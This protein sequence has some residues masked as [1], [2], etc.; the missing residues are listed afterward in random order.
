MFDDCDHLSGFYPVEQDVLGPFVWTTASGQIRLKRDTKFAQWHLCYYGNEGRLT[1]RNQRAEVI[2][3]VDLCRG[4]H[5][6]VA[7]W[8]ATAGDTIHFQVA[9]LIPVAGEPRELG[10]MLRRIELFDDQARFDRFVTKERNLGLNQREYLTGRSVLESLPPQIRINMEVRCNIPE[11]GQAC[12]YCAWDWAKEAERGSPS[13]TLNTLDELGDL[14]RSAVEVVDCSFGD[15]TMNKDFGPII[16]RLD[17]DGKQVSLTT[18]GQ[19]LTP[20]RRRELLGK[21]VF[22]YVSIDSATAAGYARYRNHRFDDII[23]NLKALC[24]EKKEHNNLPRLHVSF[25]VMRSNVAELPEFF[26]LMREVGIDEIKLRTLHLDE[27]LEL[28]TVNNGYRFDYAKELLSMPELTALTPL[29]QSLSQASGIP[30]YLDWSQFAVDASMEDAPLCGEPW[31]TLYMLRRGIMPCCF[32]TDPI[33]TWDEQQGRPLDEFL[34]DVFNSAAYQEI[35]SE[36]AAGRLSHYCRNTPSCPI[37]KAKQQQGLIEI[38]DNLFQRHA[39]VP[40]PHHGLSLPIVPIEVLTRGSAQ[41][42]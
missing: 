26:A 17:Q 15:P 16:A 10:V 36:L 14:Y 28:V 37:L 4:W 40:P 34:H 8:N 23:A 3:A 42:L 21:N 39:I 2:D 7:R 25:I 35:R 32:A 11:Q 38:S 5:S 31:K 6:I 22:L 12:V 41:V 24:R 30:A 9:P 29:V 1:F 19:M 33:A 13:F 18:N 27:N 20:K